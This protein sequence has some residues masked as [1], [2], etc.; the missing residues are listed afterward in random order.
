[1]AIKCPKCHS[2]EKDPNYALACAGL[3]DSYSI[4]GNNYF[5]PPGEDSLYLTQS[6][7][8]YAKWGKKEEAEKLLKKIIEESEK[9]YIP[10]TWIAYIY[11]F[12]GDFDQ[13]F[14]LLERAYSER[15]PDL[16][17]LKLEPAFDHL[18]S[19]PRFKALLKKMNLD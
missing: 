9:T 6:A 13:A 19:D 2:L 15:G 16:Y 5:I 4:L 8:V 18:R 11:G 3:A 14:F 10:S 1:M 7:F 12:L 17:L